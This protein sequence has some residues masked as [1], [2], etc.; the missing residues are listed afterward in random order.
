M[1]VITDF[2][3]DSYKK[4]VRNIKRKL[5]ETCACDFAECLA[6]ESCTSQVG[7]LLGL[8]R[9]IVLL[10]PAPQRGLSDTKNGGRVLLVSNAGHDPSN[11]F[12]FKVT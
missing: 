12:A 9:S 6:T 5:L 1:N 7:R 8:S 4:Q 11:V 3:Q 10:A 2:E